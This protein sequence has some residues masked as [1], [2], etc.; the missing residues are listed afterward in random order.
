MGIT[1]RY[2][3][4][5]NVHRLT[6]VQ[7]AFGSFTETKNIIVSG[8]SCYIYALSGDE[9]DDYKKKEVQVSYGMMYAPISG[10]GWLS[11]L[12]LVP[13]ESIKEADVVELIASDRIVET[14]EYDV[15]HSDDTFVYRKYHWLGLFEKE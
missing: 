1:D 5:V 10:L 14:C 12:G 6:K 4:T 11:G 3:D 8:L 13:G 9:V 2:T 7:D 15:T